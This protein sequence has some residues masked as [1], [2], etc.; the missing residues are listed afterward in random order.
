MDADNLTMDTQLLVIGGGPGGY[1][2][3]FRAAEL[4]LRTI[5]V[6]AR[7]ELG[8][9]WLHEGCM[10]NKE[11]LH[12]ADTIRA[13]EHAA[14]FGVT[15][16]KPRIDLEAL[17]N[18]LHRTVG[19]CA[20][21]LDD[22][23]REH[24]ILHVRGEAAFES[25]REVAIQGNPDVHRIRFER[26]I[27]ATGGEDLPWEGAIDH[28]ERIMSPAEALR[29]PE[30][31]PSLLVAAGRPGALEL[32][33]I[34]AALGSRVTVVVD[35][36][37][38]M[39]LADADLVELLRDQLTATLEEVCLG[40]RL[41]SLTKMEAGLIAEFEGRCAARH[42]TFDRALIAPDRRG[43]VDALHLDRTRIR[44]DRRGFIAVNRQLRTGEPRIHA[45]GD[46]TGEPMLALKATHQGR[47]AAECVAGWG[48]EFD[49]RTVPR[50][51]FTDPQIAWCG[52]TEAEAR[53]QDHPHEVQRTR[54]AAAGQTT[55][56]HRSEGFTKIIYE[57]DTQLILGLGIVG[58]N[59]AELIAE[60]AL[61][62][63]TGAILTD[64][65]ATLHPHPAHS[66]FIC[67]R[68]RGE[69]ASS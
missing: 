55:G 62:I 4:G 16:E 63:Q 32:A 22:L 13:A 65:A 20:S 27:I 51:L 66:E 21:N 39:S 23:R 1:T 30:I 31:P 36:D 15:F 69:G 5:L 14:S 8:G 64:L 3:A 33:S 17:R 53:R 9:T 11:L 59:A 19:T 2:A 7:D 57:P 50:V 42:T 54:W 46:V 40:T 48:S 43:R 52:L 10:L 26:A 60:G 45:V 28:S 68:G 12:L 49:D 61:A 29:L 47:I 38:L 24:G 56:L 25:D 18:G 58:P 34:Y 67:D 44:L 6:D 37:Q 35:D 41:R